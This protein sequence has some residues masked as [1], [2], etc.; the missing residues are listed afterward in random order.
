MAHGIPMNTRKMRNL[1]LGGFSGSLFSKPLQLTLTLRG[2][3]IYIDKNHCDCIIFF[4]FSGFN[5]LQCA[6]KNQENLPL[7]SFPAKQT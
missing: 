4:W 5:R 6:V 3:L 7:G 2:S 1:S